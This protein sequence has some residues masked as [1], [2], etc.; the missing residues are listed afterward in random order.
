MRSLPSW[1][2][3]LIITKRRYDW[4]NVMTKT[5]DRNKVNNLTWSSDN[6]EWTYNSKQKKGTVCLCLVIC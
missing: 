1:V 6:I 3:F 2:F 5:E 4:K